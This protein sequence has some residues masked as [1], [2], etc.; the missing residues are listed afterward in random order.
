MRAARVRR[1]WRQ[2]DLA[3]RAG[4]STATVSRLER[5]AIDGMPLGTIRKVARVLE[6]AVELRPRSRNAD[7]DRLVNARHAALA[8]A[9]IGWL[10][11]FGGWVVRPELSFS[12]FGE[13][14]VIDLVAWHAERRMLLVVELK[15]EI[16]DVGELIGTFDRKLRLA[17][18][19]V[20]DLGW[21]P[22]AV[23]ACLIVA[24]SMTNRRRVA[25]HRATFRSFL[26]D[27][28]LPLR[29]WLSGG[30]TTAG[31]RALV[32]FSND[33]HSNVRSAFAAARRVRAGSRRAPERG[34]VRR[35]SCPRS[36]P[37]RA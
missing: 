18:R 32:F 7:L 30:T 37:A 16:V 9:V 35:E 33:H 19:A 1:A 15:T 20:A 25:T 12:S 14:G 17:G 31:A 6:I 23:G 22:A 21:Q 5:G 24:E 4:V 8:E 26:P 2:L 29:R 11:S 10:G 27:G 36:I 3:G 28:V 13:R 34:D